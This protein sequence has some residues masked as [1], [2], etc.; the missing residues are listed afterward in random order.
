MIY[1]IPTPLGDNV[2]ELPS[3]NCEVIRSLRFFVVENVR[4][5]R[6]FI[7]SLS[8]GLDISA[9]EFVELSEHTSDVEVAE[10]L[11]RI[12]ALG[13]DCGLMSEAGLPCVADPGSRL[14]ALAHTRGIA[15]S[16][17]VGPSSIMLALMSSGLSGQ[18]FAFNGYLPIKEP[19][20]SALLKRAI[21]SAQKG[22]TQIFI[23]TP[24]RNNALMDTLLRELPSS[25]VVCVAR[26]LM[27][28]SQ[29][30]ESRAVGKWKSDKPSFGKEPAIFI[31]GAL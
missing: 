24:Y 3:L 15:V 12:V 16:P 7:S 29:R 14:V 30:I 6:R 17:L 2:G 1:L 18:N 23:E 22:Q 21:S 9:L 25:M 8:L 10:I 13:G 27:C 19:Q 28:L 26:N 11:A 4:T 5:A 20:R 31:F